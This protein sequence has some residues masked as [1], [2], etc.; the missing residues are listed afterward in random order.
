MRI[1]A[2]IILTYFFGFLP[3]KDTK[4]TN[5]NTP[6]LSGDKNT[7]ES[8]IEDKEYRIKKVVIDAGHGGHDSGC[9]YNDNEEKDNT[10]AMALKLG[11][12][13]KNEFPNI[14]VIYTR[15]KDVFVELHKRAEIA[16]KAKAD[17]FISIHC[18]ATDEG[19]TAS[20]TETYVLGLHRKGDNFEVARRENGA[21]LLESDYEK[22]YDGF[23][24]NSNEAYIIFSMFQNAYLERSILFAKLAEENLKEE[25]NRK[26]AGVKQA[27]F[28]VLR[29][30]TMPSVLIETGFLNNK[31]DGQYISSEEG[32]TDISAAIMA[33]FK[34]YKASVETPTD[35][36]Q[37][38]QTAAHSTT[39]KGSYVS[40]PSTFSSSGLVYKI[41]L[42]SLPNEIKEWSG[43]WT[44]VEN[45]E[46]T[47]ENNQYKYFWGGVAHYNDA[48]EV[49]KKVKLM[50]FEGAFLV[51]Y[52]DGQRI[53]IE[54]AKRM[55]N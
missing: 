45:A 41:Q 17:L 23:D 44:K 29:E 24:P 53:S 37:I 14:E 5:I 19:N 35:E 49:L 28:L 51:A 22:Q 16:N 33:A 26:S 48:I 50:G 38:V 12:K 27:G 39:A 13:I 21:I 42:A 54:A 8:V 40:S 43:K 10:L 34:K 2:V 55:A 1:L 15:E 47:F 52:K 31:K 20:G 6:L 9:H 4:N 18:N 30:T 25:T 7:K 36:P 32:Q 11:A 46:A 3:P